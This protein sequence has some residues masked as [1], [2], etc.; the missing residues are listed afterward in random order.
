[1]AWHGEDRNRLRVVKNLARKKKKK[2]NRVLFKRGN[3]GDG[4]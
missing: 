4:G 1:M 2:R 3:G